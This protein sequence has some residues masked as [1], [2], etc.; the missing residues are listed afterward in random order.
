MTIEN[1]VELNKLAQ[2]VIENVYPPV[3]DEPPITAEVMFPVAV[4]ILDS[5][6][7]EHLTTCLDSIFIKWRLQ[8]FALIQKRAYLH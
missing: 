7:R 5:L 4:A 1:L 3:S 6:V 2:N 8:G